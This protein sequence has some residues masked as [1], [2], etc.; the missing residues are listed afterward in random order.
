[1]FNLERFWF[2]F[3]EG[4]GGGNNILFLGLDFWGLKV[5]NVGG[6]GRGG[7]IL[8]EFCL[9]VVCF[10]FGFVGDVEIVGFVVWRFVSSVFKNLIFCFSFFF[11]EGFFVLFGI[12]FLILWFFLL[13]FEIDCV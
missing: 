1:M 10:F 11:I 4:V 5:L 2:K 6:G 7:G 13:D 3:D 9:F 12:V 8:G